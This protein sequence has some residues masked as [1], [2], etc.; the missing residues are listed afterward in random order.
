MIGTRC[1]YVICKPELA[2]LESDPGYRYD[3]CLHCG[4]AEVRQA[5]PLP[6]VFL[7]LHMP[8]EPDQAWP[9]PE[10][11]RQFG[12]QRGRDIH[13]TEG[14]GLKAALAPTDVPALYNV[15]D[16]LL[17]LTG[18]EGFGLPA[19]EAMCS[20][21]PVIYTNY[22]SHAEFLGRANGGLP[23]GGTLQPEQGSC[24]WRMIADVPQV[25]AAARKLYFNRDLGATLG[26]NGRAFVEGFT[27]EIQVEKWHQAFQSL[28]VAAI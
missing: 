1:A 3:V 25:I 10:L 9:V 17:Y 2:T 14:H 15:W 22:S 16:G 11:E 6:D 20:A 4:G 13:Y 21:L 19:W 5:E 23:V 18:G 12:L 28:R 8:E 24:V 27:P 7:W 26:R